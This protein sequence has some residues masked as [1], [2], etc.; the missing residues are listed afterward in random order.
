MW[1]LKVRSESVT[2]SRFLAWLGF[3]YHW[4]KLTTELKSPLTTTSI[5][6]FLHVC[7]KP[8]KGITNIG[9]ALALERYKKKTTLETTP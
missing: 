6:S 2:T 5:L 1:I 8:E 3:Y 4:V 9:W 7:N